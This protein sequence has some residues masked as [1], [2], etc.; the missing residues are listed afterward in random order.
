MAASVAIT[1]APGSEAPSE[2]E[3]QASG[4]DAR[5]ERVRLRAST[6]RRLR[7][8]V[9]AGVCNQQSA[10][11]LSRELLDAAIAARQQGCS[12]VLELQAALERE[13][14]PRLV[15][16]WLRACG[17]PDRPEYL[18]MLVDHVSQYGR[19]FCSPCCSMKVLRSSVLPGGRFVST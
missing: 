13:E 14:Q 18:C 17:C 12:S 15:R 19:P 1:M 16:A 6:L 7:A 2:P 10:G 9:S 4:R 5:K 3:G 11:Q 8:L